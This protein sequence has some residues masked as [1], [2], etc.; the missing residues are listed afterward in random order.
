MKKRFQLAPR[1][2]NASL[3]T[4]L[5]IALIGTSVST[6]AEIDGCISFD[7]PLAMEREWLT[8]A[9]LP[10]YASGASLP[11]FP[12][13]GFV[14]K[15]IAVQDAKFPADPE[16]PATRGWGGF[17]LLPPPEKPGLYQITLSD[18]AWIDVIQAGV[19]VANQ[20]HTGRPDCAAMR[21]SVRFELGTGPVTLQLSGAPNETA[22]I[23]I[24][25][26]SEN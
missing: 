15:L 25:R 22:K 17:L 3:A 24:R 18:T 21:K 14:L 16:K 12:E 4:L 8:N 6:G 23:A 1:R 26:V 20:A 9:N 11:T 7:W 2:R 10:L 5:A 19:R 13:G